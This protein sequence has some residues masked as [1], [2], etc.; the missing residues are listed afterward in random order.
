VELWADTDGYAPGTRLLSNR[1]ED[2]R[3]FLLAEI[4][5]RGLELTLSDGQTENRVRSDPGAL[6]GTGA[7]HVVLIVDGGAN[8]MFFVIDGRVNDGAM[9][10][11]F[12][13]QRMSPHLQSPNGAADLQV[14]A[15]VHALRVY[16]R[17]LLV[18]EAVGNYRAG[19]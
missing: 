3:G 2:G 15:P 12:G 17:A 11:Q 8:I 13:W 1:S 5:D 16:D 6:S 10:R 18:S 7:H 4:R 19:G 14:G 9:A